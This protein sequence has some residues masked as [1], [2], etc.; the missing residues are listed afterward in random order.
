MFCFFVLFLSGVTPPAAGCRGC[1]CC[2]WWRRWRSRTRRGSSSRH[3]PSD[4]RSAGLRPSPRPTTERAEEKK[5]N[6]HVS[7]KQT[8]LS[9]SI[10]EGSSHWRRAHLADTQRNAQLSQSL[11]NGRCHIGLQTRDRQGC[12]NFPT[13]G[14]TV[15]R[16]LNRTHCVRS[17]YSAALP[18]RQN[19]EKIY[20]YGDTDRGNLESYVRLNFRRP[21]VGG[22]VNDRRR[23][24]S[25][26][27][28]S[29]FGANAASK[30]PLRFSEI[31]SIL[32]T[33]AGR[34]KLIYICYQRDLVL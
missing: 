12:S 23:A 34:D 18:W 1:R 5:V 6:G 9:L 25:Q 31:K 24:T 10:L 2:R 20:L 22:C 27:W 19:T 17:V 7:S 26:R 14:V 8:T 15:P 28:S 11:D 30:S 13:W 16:W 21:T 33:K 32:K 3:F 4:R 29:D